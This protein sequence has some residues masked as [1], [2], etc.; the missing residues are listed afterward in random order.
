[1]KMLRVAVLCMLCGSVFY[2]ISASTQEV[3]C[4][5]VIYLFRH[6]EDVPSP[7]EGNP[8]TILGGVEYDSQLTPAGEQHAEQY[9]D[10]IGSL[11][12]L[13]NDNLCPVVKVYT[14]SPTKPDGTKGTTNPYKTALPLAQQTT[15]EKSPIIEIGGKKIDEHFAGGVTRYELIDDIRPILNLGH[16]VAFFWTSQG[17]PDLA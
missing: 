5:P 1:M 6:A 9:D 13:L 10:M 12:N 14:V 16:S 3:P 2:S 17:L 4:T 7:P 11:R 15:D 8:K